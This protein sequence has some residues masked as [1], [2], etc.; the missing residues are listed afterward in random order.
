MR[1]VLSVAAEE[2]LAALPVMLMPHVPD[3]FVPVVEGAPIVLYEMVCAADPLKVVPEAAPV[4]ALLKVNADGV[5]AVMVM[6]ADPLNETPLINRAV[7]SVAALVAEVALPL[8]AAV[9]VPALK[10]PE[11]SRATMVEAVF[12]LVALDVTV[13]F[14]DTPSAFDTD[15]PTPETAIAL[16]LNVLAA[17]LASMP[18]LLSAANAVRSASRGCA[19]VMP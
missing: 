9:I 12:A 8:S 15:S 7:L 5:F 13:G 3:A 14:P 1:A 18:V 11:A 6:S 4:P 17:V 2:A 19:S 16:V 10:F